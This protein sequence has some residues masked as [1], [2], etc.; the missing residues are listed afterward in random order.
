MSDWIPLRVRDHGD[1][2]DHFS[3]FEGVPPFLRPS[4]LDWLGQQLSWC[5]DDYDDLLIR[6]MQRRLRDDLG[7]DVALHGEASVRRLFERLRTDEELL[8]EAVDFVLSNV[9]SG[10]ARRAPALGGQRGAEKNRAELDRLLREAGS[11]WMV[12]GTGDES[13]LERR[14]DD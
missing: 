1:P 13:H 10:D 11:V 9:I 14:L 8:L 12:V 7:V 5:E 2:G 4:L 3:P 6:P